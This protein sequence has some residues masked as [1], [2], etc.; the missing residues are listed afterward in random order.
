MRDAFHKGYYECQELVRKI[1]IEIAIEKVS[2]GY[3]P[4]WDKKDFEKITVKEIN[5]KNI[6]E[7]LDNLLYNSDLRNMKNILSRQGYSGIDF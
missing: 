6:F 5:S 3:T 2:S 7:T 4:H 1:N